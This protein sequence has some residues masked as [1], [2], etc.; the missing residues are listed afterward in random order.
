[1]QGAGHVGAVALEDNAE[2]EGDE[3]A[4]REPGEGGSAV[5][6]RAPRA[7]GDDGVEAHGFGSGAASSSFE[8]EGDLGLG[9]AGLDRAEQMGEERVAE[10]GGA[11][12]GVEFFRFFDLAEVGD[13]A[14]AGKEE[15]A[16]TAGG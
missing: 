2:V 5:R 6:E 10:I 4:A 1:M 3:A 14:G 12:H 13:E 9:H 8:G 11:A 15:P 7:G 16:A